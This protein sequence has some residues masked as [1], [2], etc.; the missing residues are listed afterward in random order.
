MTR[1]I[2]VLILLA[3]AS[4][5][6]AQG[7]APTV[8]PALEPVVGRDTVLAV[9]FFGQ[10]DRP[11]DAIAAA[12]QDIGGRVRHRS[13]W[14]HAVS[15]D[16]TGTAL[17]T[18]RSR[19]AF[20]HLQP[21]ARFGGTPESGN[22]AATPVAA[23][24]A[25]A[26]LDSLFGPSAMPLRS[27]NAFPL[28]A[29][30][31]RGAGVTIAILDT[32]FETG[33]A[34]FADVSVLAQ[35]D[36]VFDDSVVANEPGDDPT[37]SFHG[38]AVW[39]LLAADVPGS[40]VGIAPEAEY[41][42]AKTEDVRSETRVE[43]DHWVAAIEWADALGARVVTSSLGYLEF[44]ADDFSY[45]PEQLNGDVAVTTVAADA[46]VERGIVVVTAAGNGGPGFRTLITPGDGD[47]VLTIGAEDSLGVLAGFSARGPTAD[48]RLK[49]D[50]TAPGVQVFVVNPFAPSGFSRANGTSFA[51]PL[52]AGAAALLL[53]LNPGQSPIDV[54]SAFRRYATRTAMP[55]S[56][57]GWG[58]PDIARSAFFPHGVELTAPRDSVLPSITPS[59]PWFVPDLPVTALPL[60]YRVQVARD[61]LFLETVLDTIVEQQFVQLAEPQPAGSRLIYRV[62]ASTADS[63]T[64][65]SQPS[66]W[67]LTPPWVTDLQP[68]GPGGVTVRDLRPT[69]RWTSPGVATPPGPFV[70]DLR[71]E[72]VDDG[73]IEL[74]V[75][76]LT[77]REYT[78][79]RDLE[80]NTP[81]RWS[82]TARLGQD[83][84]RARSAGGFVIIDDSAPVTTLL[85]QNFPNP[86]PNRELMRDATCIWFD[87]AENARVRLDILD[88]RGHIVRTLVP[89]TGFAAVLSPG[90][91]GRPPV[92]VPGSCDPRLEWDGTAD[93]GRA[94][95]Q[96]VYIVRLVTPTQTFTKRIVFM[97]HD[98]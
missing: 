25:I 87:L 86:F 22:P 19:Q 9:W 20:R 3:A 47:S 83:S 88:A 4:A 75:R 28:T 49:P 90:R 57:A 94:V 66:P 71:V 30:G 8:S 41:V 42:L 92:D 95:P 10:P 84:A 61:T 35:Y 85:F 48:Q 2:L 40:V 81:Y 76:D 18:A 1:P 26:D 51:T 54:R 29:R 6:A 72:R 45:S 80:R 69:F 33:H 34:A 96:G 46:A 5:P 64:A 91:Y 89:G 44:T 79:P 63:V 14:L 98:L 97:G 65:R 74:E 7:Q 17:A 67:Y 50:L 53:E 15:A 24:G 16:V 36:F 21:V 39:S 62:T 12:V 43:E 11:L 32:G 82:V 52:V 38:T 13:R 27:L 68:D 93:D 78:P 59:L 37:A 58:R 56:S 31:H 70:Y 60:N 55:D 23:P 77:D 73:A